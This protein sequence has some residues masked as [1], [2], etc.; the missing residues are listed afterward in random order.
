[1]K[2]DGDLFV[3]RLMKLATV[4]KQSDLAKIIGID[5]T[6][7]SKWRNAKRYPQ[8]ET[9]IEISKSLNCSIDDIVGYSATINTQKD[10]FD[11]LKD[12]MILDMLGTIPFEV[13]YTSIKDGY[14]IKGQ[15]EIIANDIFNSWIYS[16]LEEYQGFRKA[17]DHISDTKI[18]IDMINSL[19]EKHKNYKSDNLPW[20]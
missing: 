6:K 12:F 13:N 3:D 15:I 7:I 19:I 9:L 18:K 20:K 1:M 17:F 8:T 2:Y 5:E 10:I 14:N 4:K 11:I 16:L